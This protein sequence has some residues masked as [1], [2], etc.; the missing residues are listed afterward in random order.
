M[1]LEI[2]KLPPR[3]HQYRNVVEDPKGFVVNENNEID[4]NF[5]I[6]VNFTFNDLENGTVIEEIICSNVITGECKR[7]NVS[8]FKDILGEKNKEESD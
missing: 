5:V 7:I 4:E 8:K 2:H 6:N 1:L 3:R